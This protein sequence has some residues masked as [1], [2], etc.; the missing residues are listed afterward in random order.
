MLTFAFLPRELQP[1]ICVIISHVY[2]MLPCYLSLIFN[3]MLAALLL[4][5]PILLVPGF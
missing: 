1:T 2:V 3:H 5:N 4:S